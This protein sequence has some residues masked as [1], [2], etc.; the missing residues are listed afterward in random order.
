MACESHTD[1]VLWNFHE[2][3]FWPVLHKLLINPCYHHLTSRLGGRGSEKRSNPPRTDWGHRVGSVPIAHPGNCPFTAR[4]HFSLLGASSLS[5]LLG[6]FT[7]LLLPGLVSQPVSGIIHKACHSEA[8]FGLVESCPKVTGGRPC[9][10]A[11]EEEP[12]SK[13]ISEAG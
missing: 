12:R 13:V 7:Y 11:T 4:S 5:L 3:S 9:T 6:R 10:K 8:G 1:G 2:T